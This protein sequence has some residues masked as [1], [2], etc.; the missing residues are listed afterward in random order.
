MLNKIAA[1]NALPHFILH[2][3]AM[4]LT[5]GLGI[6]TKMMLIDPKQ[7]EIGKLEGEIGALEGQI[8]TARQNQRKVKKFEEVEKDR[9]AKDIERCLRRQTIWLSGFSSTVCCKDLPK[10]ARTGKPRRSS[11]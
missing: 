8:S 2:F 9:L 10:T 11:R 6:A 5:V 1:K 4:S 3:V 7:K